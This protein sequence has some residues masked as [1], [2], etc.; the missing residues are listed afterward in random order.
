MVIILKKNYKDVKIIQNKEEFFNC[1]DMEIFKLNGKILIKTTE[2]LA[3][4]IKIIIY[5]EIC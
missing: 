4:N 2:F 1:E 3:K 5:I